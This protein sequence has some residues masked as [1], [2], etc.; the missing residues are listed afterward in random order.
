MTP[1]VDPTVVGIPYLNRDAL[2]LLSNC[3][4]SKESD[5][6]LSLGPNWTET[7]D[8]KLLKASRLPSSFQ[9]IFS[10]GWAPVISE[11]E[12]IGLVVPTIS[13]SQLLPAMSLPEADSHYCSSG[14]RS[15][16]GPNQLMM[17]ESALVSRSSNHV[18]QTI[19]N[20]PQPPP[21]PHH[22]S[23]TN[24]GVMSSSSS[25][26]SAKANGALSSRYADPMM[27]TGYMRQ[28]EMMIEG[29]LAIVDP[30]HAA[31]LQ[32]A[33]H[34]HPQS[35]SN[36]SRHSMPTSE[37]SSR[38]GTK[39]PA[40]GASARRNSDYIGHGQYAPP[41]IPNGSFIG[42]QD[43]HH[44][45]HHQHLN[46]RFSSY[47]PTNPS[48]DYTELST[49]HYAAGPS[50]RHIDGHLSYAAG[51]TTQP[52]SNDQSR[53]RASK[54]SYNRRYLSEP[55]YEEHGHDDLMMHEVEREAMLVDMGPAQTEW[56]YELKLR[57]ALIVRV[58][59]TR[60][61]N[62]D[63][64]LTVKRG[65]I[66]EILDDTRKWWKARNIDLQVAYV[67]HTIVAVMEHYQ[68]LDELLTGSSGD[69]MMMINEDQAAV[70]N[71]QRYAHHREPLVGE[72]D[73][74]NQYHDFREGRRNSK[75]AKGAFRYF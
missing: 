61:A 30:D 73:Y 10:D 56:F 57:G 25:S 2:D 31:E 29:P 34:R 28:P 48:D 68:T 53:R 21:L 1:P 19:R 50:A 13:Q 36:S 12:L 39:H 41:S 70:V 6:W 43:D 11:L 38:S 5:L 8:A 44:H 47:P 23:S 9:P 22:P 55:H 45:P 69:M 62:N 20:G 49:N 51:P 59:F 40:H 75:T 54:S 52:T 66:L 4:T 67:P 42:P 3:C 24:N 18:E 27:Q 64:E 14:V 15:S 16:G 63:K 35:K 72:G 65:E 32:M 17:E 60:E 58:L 26:S 7:I 37:K 46:G 33:H 74:Q 71:S